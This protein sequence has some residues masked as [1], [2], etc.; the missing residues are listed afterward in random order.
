VVTANEQSDYFKVMLCAMDK[1]NPELAKKTKHI[2]HGMM[3]LPEGKMSSRTGKVITGESLIEKVEE[4]VKEKIKGRELSEKE[5]I[6]ITEAVAIGAIRYS[7]LK[8]SIGSD[9]IYDFDKSISFEG[10]S[11]PYLQYSYTRAKSVL[12]KSKAEKIKSSLEK[13]PSEITQLEKSLSYFPE[14]VLKAGENYEPHFLVLYLTELAGT[15]NAY[16]AKNKIVDKADEFSPYK[17]ALTNAFARI[18]KNG[19]WMLGINSL[20]KM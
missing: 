12:K 6:E 7:I 17:V 15:F 10:D 9:I 8:Q 16:Y 3:R 4:L 20:E 5:K 19:M 2:G 14:M 13:V 1:I 18:M 11:G